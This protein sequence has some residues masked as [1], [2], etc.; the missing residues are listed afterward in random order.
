MLFVIGLVLYAAPTISSSASA[1][2]V[3]ISG[4]STNQVEVLASGWFGA[5]GSGGMAFD[6]VNRG[7]RCRIGG[8]PS[9]SFLNKYALVVDSHDIHIS[10]MLFSEPKEVP[11]TLPRGAVAT[12]GVSWDDNPIGKQTCPMTARAVVVLSQ[13]V[14]NLWGEVPINSEPCGGTLQVTPIESGTWPQPNG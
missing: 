8:Y 3:R 7:V 4:C 12:F 9:V 5:M 2:A 6:I 13:G 10:S 14:G 1:A 11:V